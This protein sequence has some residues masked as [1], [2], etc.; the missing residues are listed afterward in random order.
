MALER[1][2][3][4]LQHHVPVGPGRPRRLRRPRRPRTPAPPPLPPRIRG[5]DPARESRIAPPREPL[6]REARLLEAIFNPVDP[7]S[8]RKRGPRACPWLE[9]GVSDE[10]FVLHP[11]FAGVATSAQPDRITH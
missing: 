9:Q 2:L 3:R 8:P 11:A 10:R 5:P 4:R 6:L 7:S 1:R